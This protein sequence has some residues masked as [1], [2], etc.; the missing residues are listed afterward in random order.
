MDNGHCGLGGQDVQLRVEMV[1][2]VV[3]ELVPIQ[4]HLAE[5]ANVPVAQISHNLATIED[6]QVALNCVYILI[7]KWVIFSFI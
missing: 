4:R 7:W 1:T 6:V 2:K 3:Q 5:V